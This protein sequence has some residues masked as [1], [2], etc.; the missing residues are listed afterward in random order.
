VPVSPAETAGGFSGAGGFGRG[1][2]GQ[3]PPGYPAPAQRL[4]LRDLSLL[5]QLCAPADD[6]AA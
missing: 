1:A 3:L 2:I 4:L 6:G 5:V